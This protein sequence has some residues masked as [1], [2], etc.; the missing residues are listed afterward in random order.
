MRKKLIQLSALFFCITFLAGCATIVRGSSQT[1]TINSNVNGAI[2][3]MNG[4]QIGVTP[5]S[6]KFKKGKER[7][8][9]ISKQGYIA[10]NIYLE[11]KYDFAASGF[12]NLLLGGT[13]GTT[14]DWATGALWLY[15]PGSFFVHLQEDGQ[16][17]L[18][19]SRELAIRK[20]AM[21]NHSQIAIDAGENHGEYVNALADLMES[22]VNR[23]TATQNINDALEKSKG[24]QVV[25]GDELIGSFRNH[26]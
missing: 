13:S 14:T 1:I 19:F 26:N 2:V 16:S 18:D 22:K 12:G 9:K 23:D 5:F 24:D 15:E 8:I 10:Q 3:E 4:Q 25:F 7:S 21:I 20:F 11:K 17:S 6:G